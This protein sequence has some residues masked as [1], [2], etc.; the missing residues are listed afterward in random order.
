MSTP[1]NIAFELNGRKIDACVSARTTVVELLR[2]TFRLTG[3]KVSCELQVCGVCTVLVDSLAVSACSMLACDLDGTSLTTIEGVM[4]GTELHPIQEA[5]IETNAFQCGFCTPGFVMMT[6]A[7]LDREPN[8]TV[9]TTR[10]W[11]DGNICRCTGYQPIER[12]VQVASRR[13]AEIESASD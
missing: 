3:T 4:Q 12:A 6:L 2:D 1:V 5:F 7:L 10:D 9:E 11:L 13:L 8:P